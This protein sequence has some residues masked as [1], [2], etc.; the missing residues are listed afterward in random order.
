MSLQPH[1]PVVTVRAGGVAPL[2][3]KLPENERA[4]AVSARAYVHPAIADRIVVRLSPEAVAA[5]TDAEMNALGFGEP[6]VEADLGQ[7]R[8]RTLGFPAWALVHDPKK[9]RF[10]LEVTQDFRKAK[11]RATSKPGHA[12]EAFDGIAKKLGR[13][14]PHFLPSFWEECGRVLADQSANAMAAQCFEKAREAERAHKLK[15]DEEARDAV[16]VEF[17]LLGALSAKTLSQYAKDLE[18]SAGAKDA[19]RR[20]RV[21]VVQRALGGMPPW[22]GMSKDLRAL[23]KAAKLDE[24]KEDDALLK[25]LLDSPSLRRAPGEFWQSYKESI[26][27]VAKDAHARARLRGIF[28][29]PRTSDDDKEKKFRADWFALLD[30]VK[31]WDDVPDADLAD[32]LSRAIKY[33][34][35]IEPIKALVTRFGPRLA[36]SETKLRVVVGDYWEQPSLD[37]AELALSLGVPLA[38]PKDSD[39]DAT[40]FDDEYECDPVHVAK[41]PV[42]GKLLVDLVSSHFGDAEHE[43]KQRGKAGFLAARRAWLEEEVKDLE[44]QGLRLVDD[45]LDLLEEK[46][47]PQTFL[48]FPDLYARI[49]KTKIAP[50]LEHTLRAGIADELGWEAYEKAFE[51]LGEKVTLEGYFPYV[52]A[53]DGI[54]ARVIGPQGLALKHDFSIDAKKEKLEHAI[55][56]DGDLLVLFEDKKSYD[57]KAYWAKS[58][59]DR[60]E[61]RLY[62][63]GGFGWQTPLEGGGVTVG[64]LPVR[65]GDHKI[66]DDGRNYDHD[67]QTFFHVE[68]DG[69]SR[70][71]FEWDPLTN[72]RGRKSRPTFFEQYIEEGK[73]LDNDASWLHVAPKGMTTSL[74]GIKDGLLGL[75][76]RKKDETYEVER[77]DGVKWTGKDENLTPHALAFFPGNDRP[78]VLDVSEANDKRWLG[79]EIVSVDLHSPDG[80]HLASLNEDEWASKGWGK[81]P[82]P[83]LAMWHFLSYRDEAAS[84]KLRSIDR[85]DELMIEDPK[86]REAAIRARGFTNDKLVEGISGVVEQ[87]I[88]LQKRLAQFVDDRSKEAAERAPVSGAGEKAVAIHKLSDALS[89]N[90][91]VVIEDF[92]DELKAWLTAGRGKATRARMPFPEQSEKD[93]A[94][95]MM[96]ALAGTIFE[97]ALPNMRIAEIEDA[98]EDDD[99][100]DDDYEWGALYVDVHGASTIG[101][102][103][104][105]DWMIERSNDGTFRIPKGHKV[106]SDKRL[107]RGPGAQFIRAWLALE[108]KVAPWD[109]AVADRLAEKTG[110]SR[111]EA[112]L[113]AAGLPNIGDYSRDFLGKERREQLNLKVTEADPARGTFREIDSDVLDEIFAT[114]VGEEPASVLTPLTPDASGSC[115]ADRLADAWLAKFGKRVEMPAELLE[116]AQK[117]LDLGRDLHR[118]LSALH[119]PESV[120]NITVVERSLPDVMWNRPEGHQAFTHEL[121]SRLMLTIAWVSYA[122]PVGDRVRDKIP[123]LY[124]KMRKVLEDPKHLWP[125]GSMYSDHKEKKDLHDVLKVIGGDK[126]SLAQDD[127]DKC[128]DARDDGTL[129]AG[130]YGHRLIAGFRPAKV[131]RWDAASFQA[132]MKAIGED[133]DS[134]FQ[135]ARALLSDSF[136]QLVARLGETKVEKGQFEANPLLSTPKTVTAVKK[137]HGISEEAAALY[138]QLLALAE[139]TDRAIRRFNA[140][141][142][143]Q[144]Q[145]AQAELVKKKLVSEGKRE[146]AGREVFLPGGWGKGSGKDLPMEDWKKPFYEA[147]VGRNLP[148]EPLHTLYARAWKRVESGDGPK[149]EK[150]R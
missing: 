139:P 91:S 65:A 132:V 9:A 137:E 53:H 11:K 59:K 146:R 43:K 92:P 16:F 95:E 120:T 60:F 107:S 57:D 135:I 30:Q 29:E 101:I 112:I 40:S 80:E 50:A 119:A 31:A 134:S 72:K 73:E 1:D 133:D 83:P 108:D 25:E 79:G 63:S 41:D 84:K 121:G 2:K 105:S 24:G 103:R 39:G 140:W 22:S 145:S 10:A 126:V 122:T 32:L 55:Y 12:K 62:M 70:S 127:D 106:T 4:S 27:R 17:A 13:T 18:K 19:W 56:L 86:K 48:E 36:A 90:K 21:I 71:Y 115:F 69:E 64:H 47:N 113:L 37:L 78:H 42:Y 5:G 58:P 131:K 136:A 89:R 128:E 38:E 82:L 110:L 97:D 35:A 150:V 68:W 144:H 96:A 8:Y 117:D 94:K 102:N 75:R 54:H 61:L 33:G 51:G 85:V 6:E 100:D 87:S 34:G 125:L 7:M 124:A 46:T 49:A 118:T 99:N 148:T 44:G 147:N 66:E 93:E 143:K 76:A 114:A 129:V 111:A 116:A 52:V 28:P 14:V 149:F 104:G 3:A 74:L 98:E 138:L 45:T 26:V 23:I 142:P 123:A 141:T 67:G 15:V 77:I 88:V 81:V 109:P 130:I 20:F